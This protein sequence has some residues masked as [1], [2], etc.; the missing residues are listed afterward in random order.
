[1]TPVR[2]AS[3]QAASS[4][5]GENQ[6]EPTIRLAATPSPV[7]PV[8]WKEAIAGDVTYDM[9][10]FD[11]GGGP[12]LTECPKQIIQCLSYQLSFDGHL[13]AAL[14]R[15]GERPARCAEARRTWLAQDLLCHFKCLLF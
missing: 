6:R 2:E 10:I 3:S 9:G 1:M 13:L 8:A 14:I 15:G 11:M 4:T 5:S 7:G 12:L